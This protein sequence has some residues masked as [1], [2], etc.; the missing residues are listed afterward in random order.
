MAKRTQNEIE[1]DYL[2]IKRAAETATSFKDIE[3]ETGLKYSEI[4]TSLKKHPRVFERIKKRFEEAQKNSKSAQNKECKRDDS[5]DIVIDTSITGVP[6]IEKVLEEE[7]AHIILTQVVIK[8][9]SRM[10]HFNDSDAMR[11]RHIL[12]MPADNEDKFIHELISEEYESADKCILE[13]CL[14]KRIILF[15]IRQIKKCLT[16]LK[17]I[18]FL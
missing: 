15:Y 12:A 16:L 13:Y 8:E 11:A 3:R 4:I 18:R 1:K 17:Y 7:S 5:P 6:G 10:Q 14:K 9:L 2:S